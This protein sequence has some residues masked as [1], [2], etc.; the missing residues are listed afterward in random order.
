[1]NTVD[2]RIR[3]LTPPTE[4]DDAHVDRLW[5]ATNTRIDSKV[6]ALVVSRARRT[7]RSLR[8]LAIALGIV[9][10]TGSVAFGAS[11]QVRSAVSSVA[12]DAVDVFL[13][14]RHEAPLTEE[15]EDVM[16]RL[17]LSL[18]LKFEQGRTLATSTRN[19]ITGTLSAIP[20]GR[21]GL[22]LTTT[23]TVDGVSPPDGWSAGCIGPLSA[24]H[25]IGGGTWTRDRLKIVSGIALAD[26]VKLEVN[27]DG[28]WEDIDMNDHAFVWIAPSRDAVVGP[29]RV[30]LS[31]GDS[32][33]QSAP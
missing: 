11:A 28:R 2:E 17:D 19:N 26:V 16:G 12:V 6:P 30:T 33:I 8:P 22:C 23:L 7:R 20:R 25:P 1:M 27:V 15:A 13:D 3:T 4:L 5:A 14:Q 9:L 21:D 24:D 10:V 32:V 29:Y 31:D 18:E